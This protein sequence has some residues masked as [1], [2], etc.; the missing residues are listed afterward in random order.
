MGLRMP[1]FPESPFEFYKTPIFTDT[2]L[3]DLGVDE[4]TV[5]LPTVLEQQCGNILFRLFC[6]PPAVRIEKKKKFKHKIFMV[7]CG[8]SGMT[9]ITD[10]ATLNILNG[11]IS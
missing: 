10:P 9:I 4:E 1:I 11:C 2:N 3:S 5:A 6:H 7:N 8:P